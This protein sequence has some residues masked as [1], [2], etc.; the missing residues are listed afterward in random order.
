MENKAFSDSGK[1]F[2]LAWQEYFKGK[3]K[4]RNDE[5][6]RRQL[7]EFNYWYNNV[8]KQSDTGKTPA[9]MYKEIYGKEPPKNPTE[10]SRMINFK[11]DEDYDEEL[12]GLV[13]ELQEYDNERGYKLDYENVKEK[14]N[15]AINELIKKGERALDLLHELLEHEETW[16]CLFALEIIKEIKSPISIPHL[17]NFITSNEKEEYGDYC[18]EAM[19]A[20]NNIGEP[21]IEPLFK[22]IKY[23]FEKKE[24][25]TY[26]IGAL[27]GI[28]SEKVYLFMI[29]L[30][31]DYIENEEKYDGWFY[32][33]QF[34]YNFD[35]QENK[36]ALP[37]LKKLI[38]LDRLSN[39]GKIEIKSTIEIIEDPGKWKKK[40]KEDSKEL[41]PLIEKFMKGEND[42]LGEDIDREEIKKKMCTP[43]DDLEIQFKCHDCNKKQNIKPGLIKQIGVKLFEFSFEN[44]IMCKYCFSNNIKL[45]KDGEMEIIFQGIGTLAGI[46]QGVLPMSDEVYIENKQKVLFKKS[47]NY[48]LKRISQEPDNGELYLR[49]G[50]VARGF[51]KYNEAIKHYEKAIELNSKLIASYM[52]L[53]GM[54]EYRYKYYKIKEAKVTASFYLNEMVDLFRTQDYDPVTIQNKGDIIPFMGEMSESLGI[55]I[56]ELIKIPILPYTLNKV[57]RNE[58]CPCGSGKKYKKCCLD[59]EEEF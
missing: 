19:L 54:Y 35:K 44:E 45:T 39:Q 43:D 24:F 8:R 55:N 50:N 53:V 33:E 34:I 21:A 42:I 29:D 25:Y 40:L 17:I 23:R 10:P 56:P 12:I 28:K 31:R 38:R 48:I 1:E 16:S 4:P 22:E 20:L 59:K 46:R 27:T 13:Y 6:E 15:P 7:E 51:N 9:E 11:W 2:D 49:A 36:E 3:L 30:V 52:N 58:L 18:E 47:Y 5:E 14:L 32:I 26:L 41:K 57:G 37:L